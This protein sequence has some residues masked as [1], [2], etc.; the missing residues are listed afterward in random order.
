MFVLT[1]LAAMQ[2]AAPAVSAPPANRDDEIV[3]K[4]E[5]RELEFGSHMRAK[6]KCMTRGQW[7][8]V[9]QHTKEEL[10][11][12]QDRHLDPGQRGTPR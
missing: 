2:A 3:C 1:L 8:Y 9:E 10:R 4:R 7:A 11:R 5:E 6:K 12:L